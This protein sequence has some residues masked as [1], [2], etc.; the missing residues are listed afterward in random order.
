MD[1]AIMNGFGIALAQHMCRVEQELE[2]LAVPL[3]LLLSSKF[4]YFRA[5]LMSS[6]LLLMPLSLK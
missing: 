5:G 3:V 1:F 4:R 6:F 2:G